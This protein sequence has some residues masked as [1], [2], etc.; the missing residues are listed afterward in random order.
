VNQETMETVTCRGRQYRVGQDAAHHDLPLP[1]WWPAV[2]PPGWEEIETSPWTGQPRRAYTRAYV[3]HGTVRVI[4]S[5]AQYGDGKRWVHLS[6]S[7][8]NQQMPSWECMSEV[9]EVF[10]GRDRTALQVHPP[11]QHWVNIHPGVLHLWCCL[12]GDV[13]PDFTAGGETI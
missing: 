12:D 6:V 2:L 4:G 9:K 1:D 5:C 7:R 8:R 13:T 3:K 10:C 11:R